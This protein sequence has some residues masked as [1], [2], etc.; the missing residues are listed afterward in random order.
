MVPL[1]VLFARVPCHLGDR[2]LDPNLEKLPICESALAKP[3][4]VE[5][6]AQ[7]SQALLLRVGSEL[8]APRV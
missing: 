6:A 8:S 4:A 3:G 1:G 2:K 7:L 5:E